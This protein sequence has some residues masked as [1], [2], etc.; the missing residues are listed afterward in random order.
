MHKIES[1]CS[2][3]ETNTAPLINYVLGRFSRDPMLLCP[4]DSPGKSTKVGCHALLQRIFPI[5]GLNQRLNLSL[6][7]LLHWQADSLTLAPPGK[8]KNSGGISKNEIVTNLQ[9]HQGMARKFLFT[10]RYQLFD[11]DCTEVCAKK[12]S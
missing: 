5:Q 3:P 4:W 1:L 8:P 9:L 7:H 6:L 10:C 11:V 12:D 2:T